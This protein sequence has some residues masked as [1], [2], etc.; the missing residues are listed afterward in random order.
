M[1][2]NVPWPTKP[3]VMPFS[4][5]LIL[6]QSSWSCYS[7]DVPARLLSWGRLYFFPLLECSLLGVRALFKYS[8]PLL[9]TVTFGPSALCHSSCLLPPVSVVYFL[10]DCNFPR[11]GDVIL[12]IARSPLPRIGRGRRGRA[13]H[14]DLNGNKTPLSPRRTCLSLP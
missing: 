13:D 8:L 2:Q 14:D 6:P 1:I 12:F 3:S 9:P 11:I 7:S 4:P 5:L 10:L